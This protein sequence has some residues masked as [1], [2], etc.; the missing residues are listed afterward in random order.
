MTQALPNVMISGMPSDLVCPPEML[1]IPEQINERGI[2]AQNEGVRGDKLLKRLKN[3]CQ[4]HA[5]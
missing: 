3:Q 2:D 4:M 5:V 1:P